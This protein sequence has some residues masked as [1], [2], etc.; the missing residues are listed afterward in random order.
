MKVLLLGGTGVMG[1]YL[2]DLL[3]KKQVPTYVTSRKKHKDFGTI[4]YVQGNAKEMPF[5]TQICSQEKWDAIVDFM[6]YKTDEFKQR[7]ELLLSSTLQYIFISTA[8]V[9]GNEEHPIKETSPRLLDCSTDK[10]FLSTDEYSLTKA[11]QENI[12]YNSGK[13]N[14]TII[15]PCIIYG[16]NRLQLG[17]LEKEE[18]LYRALHGRQIVFCQEILDKVTTMTNGF[19]IARAFSEIIGNK[20]SLG[21]TIH[22]TCTHHRTW[23]Q[24]FDIYSN[25]LRDLTGRVPNMKI[26][27]LSEF[28]NSRPDYLKYQVIYDRVY[29]KDFCVEK[30]S[31]F[32]D[33]DSFLPPEV[34]LRK[35]LT[36]F[37]ENGC[38]FNY[39]TVKYEAK[40]DKLTKEYSTF[41]D[42]R[43]IKEKMKYLYYR[44]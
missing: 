34:G 2:I 9:Y 25:T 42:V 27:P 8:R 10:E 28:I 1:K 31:E 17:V 33:V 30:E 41:A 35:C 26:V 6:S 21:E 39:V 43:G 12:L 32:I 36:N 13:T 19:D 7:Y 24:I 22:L 44:F 38:P 40:R 5:L 14:Y 4:H 15:R 18:W 37:L 20:K 11:R 16:D 29:D 3:D 23:R